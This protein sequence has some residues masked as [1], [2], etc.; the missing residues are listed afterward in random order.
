MNHFDKSFRKT[1]SRVSFSQMFRD[2]GQVDLDVYLAG[3]QGE[4]LSRQNRDKH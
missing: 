2:F 1:F 4:W 3:C